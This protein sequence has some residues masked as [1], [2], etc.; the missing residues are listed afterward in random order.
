MADNL[1]DSF[2]TFY[3]TKM[4]GD[5]IRSKP[6]VNGFLTY[7]IEIKEEIHLENDPNYFR[8]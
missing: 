2:F 6:D 1:T 4:L 8:K 3:K 7:K 5:K